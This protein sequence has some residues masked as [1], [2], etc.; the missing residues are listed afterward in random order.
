M[1]LVQ[2]GGVASKSLHALLLP[3]LKKKLAA[4]SQDS[5]SLLKS[6]GEA[7]AAFDH[8]VVPCIVTFRDDKA[9][10]T[11]SYL[12]FF[13]IAALLTNLYKVFYPTKELKQY[14]SPLLTKTHVMAQFLRESNRCPSLLRRLALTPGELYELVS[15][16]PPHSKRH[17]RCTVNLHSELLQP[18]RHG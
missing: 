10:E 12:I 4:E 5:Q 7:R 11:T 2:D 1:L 8:V 14:I 15:W 18:F 17:E 9:E 16:S 13:S 6:L 3:R